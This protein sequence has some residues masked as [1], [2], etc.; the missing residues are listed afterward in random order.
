MCVREIVHHAQRGPCAAGGDALGRLGP[1]P[2]LILP[3]SGRTHRRNRGGISGRRFQ[4]VATYPQVLVGI[5]QAG[6]VAFAEESRCRTGF[7]ETSPGGRPTG[8]GGNRCGSDHQK[9]SGHRR[10]IRRWRLSAT[11][12]PPLAAF[13]AIQG[14]QGRV[15]A[16]G[17]R[18]RPF[19]AMASG[20]KWWRSGSARGTVG[21]LHTASN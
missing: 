14:R 16:M 4:Q 2:S 10:F 17:D 1:V 12:R 21:L 19:L 15:E 3:A 9:A 8:P 11:D 20:L 5:G 7:G 18:Y 13:T 6:Q